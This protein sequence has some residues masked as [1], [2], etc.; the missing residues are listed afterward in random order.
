MERFFSSK[1]NKF[2]FYSPDADEVSLVIQNHDK[3]W[4]M[5]PD[6]RGYW[7]VVPEIT[8]QQLNNLSYHYRVRV[9]Q[10]VRK[11]AD[12]LAGRLA[13]VNGKYKSLFQLIGYQYQNKGFRTPPIEK[14]VIYESH[15]PA[16][17]RHPSA[18]V[19]KEIYRGTYLGAA[20]NYLLNHIQRLHVAIE[21]LPLHYSDKELGGDWGYYSVAYS[22]MRS[23]FAV[24]KENVNTEVMQLI[25]ALHGRG[26]P[27]ILDVVFNHGAELW[28]KAWGKDVVYRKLEA[29][30][31]CNG[32][33]CGATVKT[34]NGHIRRTIV[35]TLQNL[36]N[37]YRFD[38][39]RFDLGALHDK[40]TMLEIAKRL[41]KRIYLIAEPWALGGNQ[42]GKAEMSNEFAHTRWAIWNDDFR[43]PARMFIQG[44]GDFQNRDLLMRAIVGS[45]IKDGGWAL[46]PQ[47]SVNYISCHD[48]RTLADLVGGNKH[49]AFLGLFLLL[50]SQ[51]IPMMGEG[52]EFLY[53]K[54]GHDN[55]YDRPDLNQLDWTNAIQHGDLVEA[56]GQLVDLRLQLS[57]FLYR[58]HVKANDQKS[59]YWDIDWIYP[60]GYPHHDNVNAIAYIIR[61][62]RRY[63]LWNRA[64]HSVVVLLNGSHS[65]VDFA[66][67]DGEWRVLVDGLRLKVNP[68]GLN[69]APNAK[70][71]Y[72]LQPGTC[73]MLS[74]VI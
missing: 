16:L 59:R 74:L 19:D 55:S 53:S 73:A 52:S 10:R 9:G 46:R 6:A 40:E 2:S 66:L 13:L 44:S 48:G 63:R 69:I 39:F 37:T 11:V 62:P 28:V 31:Y 68:S 36:V 60:T 71:H 23:D 8:K 42:W 45:H 56:V 20:S 41:P 3:N 57:H 12:P 24:N 25:D 29:G 58:G 7:T 1:K 49:R 70:D 35:E 50:T 33:G 15:L 26:I 61:P 30:S 18:A 32:S 54:H 17:S 22:A 47:Q 51:G 4:P 65:G 34:E 38:G 14:I 43:E 5:K 27:V 64:R 21:F 72:H 67:P